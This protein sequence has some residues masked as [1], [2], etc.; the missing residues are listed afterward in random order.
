MGHGVESGKAE[1]SILLEGVD[2]SKETDP[3]L[4]VASYDFELPKELIAQHPDPG[5]DT[6]RLMHLDRAR[7]ALGHHRFQDLPNLLHP[8]DLLVLNNTRV[9]AARVRGRRATGGRVEA[10]L[11]SRL[12]GA[13][14]AGGGVMERWVALLSPSSRLKE[15]ERLAFPGGMVLIPERWASGGWQVRIESPAPVLEL[16]EEVGETPLPPYIKRAPEA[17]RN[18]EDRERYQTVYA[19]VPGSAAAPTAGLHFT[20]ELL[21]ALKRRGVAHAFLT[22][23]VGLGTFSPVRV[24]RVSDHVMHTEWYHVPKETIEAVAEARASGRRVVA[25]G[26]TSVRTLET[27]AARPGGFQSIPD[28]GGWTGETAAFIYPGYRFR[29]VDA[30][31]TNFHVPRSSLLMLVSAFA[32]RERILKAY[33]EAVARGYRFFSYGDGML[34]T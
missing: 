5:R 18:P 28:A 2:A 34:I 29:V 32:G 11:L 31:I 15:G 16:L 10:L 14:E 7:D 21:D 19:R 23:H 24:E 27:V 17:R 3:D 30:M 26:T 25:V 8:G 22:L 1:G 4:L 6:A 33:G 12:E 20:R 9:I 13:S